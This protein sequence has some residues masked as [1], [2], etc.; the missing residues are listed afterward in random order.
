MPSNKTMKCMNIRCCCTNIYLNALIECGWVSVMCWCGL[1]SRFVCS[2]M[3]VN[4]ANVRVNAFIFVSNFPSLARSL[5]LPLSRS[6]AKQM[7]ALHT[8]IMVFYLHYWKCQRKCEYCITI[9]VYLHF[10]FEQWLAKAFAWGIERE[11]RGG[12]NPRSEGMRSS[13]RW[14]RWKHEKPSTCTR[15][16]RLS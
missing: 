6:R 11:M 5:S 13:K 10:S 16:Y 14:N 2:L 1:M 9:F 7:F 15:T 12:K 4:G 3:L 8:Y